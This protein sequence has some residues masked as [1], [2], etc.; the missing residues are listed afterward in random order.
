[1]AETAR[2]KA[3]TAGII[4]RLFAAAYDL[5]ILFGLEFLAFI[6]VTI[7]EQYAAPIPDWLKGFLLMTVAYAYFV[8]F[9]VKGATT[10]GMRPWKLRVAMAESGEPVGFAAAT[11]RFFGLMLTW[12]ALGLTLFYMAT[13]QTGTPLFFVAAAVPAVSL[14]MMLLTRRKQALHDLIAGT[15]VFRLRKKA[16]AQ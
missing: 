10:T 4:I 5:T 8:G 9:W 12:L 7:V 16:S 2:P 15:G 11:A 1:M 6:P 3:A 13:R 14:L